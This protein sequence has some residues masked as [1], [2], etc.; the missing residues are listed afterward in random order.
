MLLIVPPTRMPVDTTHHNQGQ[1]TKQ[2]EEV[3]TQDAPERPLT[4]A[5]RS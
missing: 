3:Q 1:Q 2:A 4:R 5:D